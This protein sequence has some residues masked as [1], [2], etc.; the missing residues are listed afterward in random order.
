MQEGVNVEHSR[1]VEGIVDLLWRKSGLIIDDSINLKEESFGGF[2]DP[3]VLLDS[4]NLS[5]IIAIVLNV[6][7]GHFLASLVK[8]LVLD[9]HEQQTE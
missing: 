1:K 3:A 5:F 9:I 8:L 7:N 6:G 2:F 4:N